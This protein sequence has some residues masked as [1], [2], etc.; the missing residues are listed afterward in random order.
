MKLGAK[1]R[2]KVKIYILKFCIQTDLPYRK[3]DLFF[4]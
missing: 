4:R 2:E 1:M 3:R